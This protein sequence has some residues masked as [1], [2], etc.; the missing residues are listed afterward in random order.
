M[1]LRIQSFQQ[2][3]VNLKDLASFSKIKMKI[4]QSKT[5]NLLFEGFQIS[6][7]A[8]NNADPLPSQIKFIKI[9]KL[10]YFNIR[11]STTE[12]DHISTQ[13]CVLFLK[14]E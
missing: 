6:C 1:K 8:K 13:E 12:K 9:N 10:E 11:I 7:L 5:F 2:A 14:C 3:W 4:C